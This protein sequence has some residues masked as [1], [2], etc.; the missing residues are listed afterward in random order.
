M[1][2]SSDRVGI[3]RVAVEP[4]VD[5]ANR[6]VE[7][8]LAAQTGRCGEG[9]QD[10]AISDELNRLADDILVVA[11]S[12]EGQLPLEPVPTDLSDLV[13]DM[14]ASYAERATAQTVTLVSELPATRLA[15]LVDR[16]RMRQ[17]LRNLLDNALAFCPEYGRVGVAL[18]AEPGAL[19]I[20]VTDSGPGFEHGFLTRLSSRIRALMP[21][22]PGGRAAPGSD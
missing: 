9:R 6:Q 11:R 16:T 10:A 20:V 5:L 18:V 21:A 17:V 22:A 12:N 19:R 4:D 3:Q 2:E 15:A 14:V 13:S 1:G 7:R 8:R